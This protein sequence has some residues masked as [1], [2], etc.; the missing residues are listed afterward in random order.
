MDL[1]NVLVAAVVTGG[2][3]LAVV[4]V[5]LTVLAVHLLNANTEMEIKTRRS[6]WANEAI[7]ERPRRRGLYV[8]KP[9]T[10]KHEWRLDFKD[11]EAD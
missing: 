2:V 10:E 7:R 3:L 8:R 11:A 6:D 5:C 9:V 1:D 4:T